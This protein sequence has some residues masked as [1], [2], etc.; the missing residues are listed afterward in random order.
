MTIHKTSYKV[1]ST[2]SSDIY[3][4]FLSETAPSIAK[5]LQTPIRESSIT[6]SV[7]S[8][9]DIPSNIFTFKENTSHI[10]TS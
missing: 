4:S 1:Q 10:D 5:I 6:N 7:V 2:N 3:S 9:I 8:N